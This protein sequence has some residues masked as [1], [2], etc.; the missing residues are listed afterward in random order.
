VIAQIEELK[1]FQIS[2]M[3]VDIQVLLVLVS[4]PTTACH[5]NHLSSAI[6]NLITW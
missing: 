2:E 5:I 3:L 1:L 6:S 4:A